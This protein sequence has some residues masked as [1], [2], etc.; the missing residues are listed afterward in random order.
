MYRGRNKRHPPSSRRSPPWMR[1]IK[2]WK[3]GLTT[4]RGNKR[5]SN[6]C[7]TLPFPSLASLPLTTVHTRRPA[8]SSLAPR[9]VYTAAH[10]IRIHSIAFALHHPL[11]ATGESFSSSVAAVSSLRF[12]RK[13][14]FHTKCTTKTVQP[15]Y[16]VLSR[17]I[18]ESRFQIHRRPTLSWL[19]ALHCRH[20][21]RRS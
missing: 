3:R 9:S 1:G 7:S 13:P 8:P 10:R 16:H 2:R 4:C 17:S 21:A 6:R 5:H 15:T 19:L 14:K 11:S 18:N 12:V 20:F